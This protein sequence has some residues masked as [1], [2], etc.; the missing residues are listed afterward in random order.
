MT[1]TLSLKDAL[2][3]GTKEVFETMVFMALNEVE[4]E[5]PGSEEVTLL[6]TITFTGSIQG[7]LSLCCGLSGA[8]AV[9]ANMLC[10]DSP[11]ELSGEDVVDAIGEIANMVMGSVKTRIQDQIQDIAISIP[12]VVQGRELCTCLSD[13]TVRVAVNATLADEHHATFSLVYRDGGASE[14]AG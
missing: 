7:C 14:G 6:G 5:M 1:T 4:E 11:D 12:S 3:E 9:A 8:Q 13:G 10:M 2:L